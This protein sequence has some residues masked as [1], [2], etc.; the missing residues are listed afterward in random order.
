MMSATLD[1]RAMLVYR[2]TSADN[3]MPFAFTV[4]NGE[5]ASNRGEHFLPSSNSTSGNAATSAC[6]Y[7]FNE[8]IQSSTAM[9]SCKGKVLGPI[10]F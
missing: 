9:E 4:S 5:R 7:N 8:I 2:V 6:Q 3:L 10:C 1:R